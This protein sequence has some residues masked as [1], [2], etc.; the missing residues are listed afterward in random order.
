M[1]NVT[2]AISVV[3]SA[4]AVRR[5]PLAVYSNLQYYYMLSQ[6]PSCIIFLQVGTKNARRSRSACPFN[7][8]ID[9]IAEEASL[10]SMPP[11]A[12]LPN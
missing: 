6:L 10:T 4:R 3:R 9:G 8:A 11:P 12:A 5:G 7:Q 1:S 2:L